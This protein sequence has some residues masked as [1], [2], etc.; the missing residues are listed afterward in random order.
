MSLIF[1]DSNLL[2]YAVT[3]ETK[4]D[5][6]DALIA[7]G[8]T[9]SAQVLN[10]TARVLIRKFRFTW[11][12]V[13]DIIRSFVLGAAR[14]M[15]VT[16]ETT[17]LTI[18]VAARYRLQFFDACLIAAALQAGCT[19]FYSEDMHDGLLIDDRLTIRNPFV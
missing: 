19:M 16:T 7:L 1:L 3:D 4:R 8:V 12:E 2:V 14:V 15:P 6:V 11:D 9:L 13:D 10:E 5:A 18:R 17:F